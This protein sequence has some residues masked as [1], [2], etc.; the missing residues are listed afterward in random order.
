[1]EPARPVNFRNKYAALQMDTEARAANVESTDALFNDCG[2]GN[3]ATVFAEEKTAPA[4]KTK[5][6]L[7]QQNPKLR[8]VQDVL[9][10]LVESGRLWSLL[11]S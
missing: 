11:L 4:A 6:N 1:M 7:T 9:A 3:V 10:L 8:I 2:L 5:A